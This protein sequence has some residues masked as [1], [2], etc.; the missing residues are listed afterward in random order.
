MNLLLSSV[1]ALA[2][3][4]P[5]AVQPGSR[6]D[7]PQPRGPEA[8][9]QQLREQIREL[10]ANLK[11]S[12]EGDQR[13][14]DDRR[15]EEKQDDRGRGVPMGPGGFK[16]MP[17]MG[18]GAGGSGPINPMGRGFGSG[19]S[20]GF[21]PGG[22]PGVRGGFG[23][24]PPGFDRLSA[25]E[26][27]AFRALLQKM[28]SDAPRGPAGGKGSVDERLDRLEKMIEELRRSRP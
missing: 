10:E 17:P 8:E 14:G 22:P 3:G 16:P 1:L 21:G 13:Q 7:G 9:L 25:E 20:G 19:G 26:Q 12:R 5:T 4:L 6:K 24:S 11:Q 2:V 27:K 28:T 15:G 23:Q 18:P